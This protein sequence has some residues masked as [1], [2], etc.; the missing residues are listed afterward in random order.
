MLKQK[1]KIRQLIVSALGLALLVA[2]SNNGLAFSA[3]STS[4]K[5]TTSTST[6]SN[7]NAIVSYN[8]AT[9]LYPGMIV[10]LKPGSSDTVQPLNLSDINHMLGVVVEPNQAP[11]VL[12]PTKSTSQQV[13]VSSSGQYNVLVSNQDGPIKVGDP[14]SISSIA[15]VGMEANSSEA[16][17]IGKALASFNGKSSSIGSAKLTTSFSTAQLSL[18]LIPVTVSVAHNPLLSGQTSFVPSNVSRVAA[19]ISDKPVSAA[20]IYLSLLILIV[21]VFLAGILLYSGVRSGIQ[22]IG[23]NPLSKKSIIRGLIETAITGLLVFAA[24]VSGVYLILKL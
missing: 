23:R 14:I 7:Q 19:S 17:I 18:G 21:S 1:L 9:T 12:S 22:A 10:G 13:Y 20:R 2:S 24:G 5:T 11:I 3:K 4:A 15:G 6:S 8:S 16:Y